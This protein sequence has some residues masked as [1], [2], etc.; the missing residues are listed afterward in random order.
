[1]TSEQLFQQQQQ[2]ANEQGHVPNAERRRDGELVNNAQPTPAPEST[3]AREPQPKLSLTTNAFGNPE[4]KE[5]APAYANECKPGTGARTLNGTTTANF[6]GPFVDSGP[7][8][9]QTTFKASYDRP[10]D[11]TAQVEECLHCGEAVNVSSGA[12]GLKCYACGRISEPLKL[13]R[14]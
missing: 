2:E 4:W 9:V 1:M 12:E 3:T 8:R 14:L 13:R 11:L 6:I 5:T 10:A 7:T